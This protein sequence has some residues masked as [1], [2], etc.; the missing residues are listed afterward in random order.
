MLRRIR[1]SVLI[2]LLGVV[3]LAPLFECFD[4]G[5]DMEQGNDIVL[6]LVCLFATVT[7]FVLSGRMIASLFRLLSI[8]SISPIRSLR[9]IERFIE[10]QGSPPGPFLPINNLRI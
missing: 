6:G 5:R 4:D 8:A 2:V 1:H 10:A 7:L 3:L 9:F